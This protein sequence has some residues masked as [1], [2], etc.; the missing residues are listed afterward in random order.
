MIELKLHHQKSLNLQG[1]SFTREAVRA[2][3]RSGDRVLFIHSPQ[4][5]DYKLP[6]GGIEAGENHEEALRREILEESGYIISD[7]GPQIALISEFS[8][9][10]EPDMDFFR[11][12]SHYYSCEVDT[13]E[14]TVQNL[15]D[16]EKALEMTPVWIEP[17]KALELNRSVLK[18]NPSP[19]RWTRREILFLES[20]E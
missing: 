15:D 13:G 16:Y 18:N 4:N 19:P 3:I 17:A 1:N 6:G 7:M 20:L 14:Q 11:M 2:Y 8:E 9:A 5:G 10:A 12:N